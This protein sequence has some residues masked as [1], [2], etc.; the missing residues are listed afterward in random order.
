[1]SRCTVTLVALASLTGCSL[2][3]TRAVRLQ[4]AQAEVVAS[5]RYVDE[6]FG[7]EVKRPSGA[8]DLTETDSV[9]EDGIAIPI[10]LKHRASGAQVVLQVA[11]AVATPTQYA[12]RI[13]R[14]LARQAG[15]ETSD[16]RPLP[17]S[18]SAVGFDFSLEGQMDGKVAV[19]E[20]GPGNIFMLMATWPRGVAATVPQNVDAI[21]ESLQP[22]PTR[23]VAR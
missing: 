16:L 23:I 14:G 1:M 13:T 2:F 19:R 5:R 17:L 3:Q 21:F 8:W 9:T 11:P 6:T 12:E 7:F 15:F 20:G 10:I 18:D 22:V 4:R